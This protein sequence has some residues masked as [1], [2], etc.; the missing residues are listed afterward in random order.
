MQPRCQTGLQAFDGYV[1]LFHV[2]FELQLPV[3]VQRKVLTGQCHLLR[4]R[5]N[6]ITLRYEWG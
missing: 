1:I 4:N 3:A 6:G 5:Q 2:P